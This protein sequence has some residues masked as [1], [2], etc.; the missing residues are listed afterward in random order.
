[1]KEADRMD[2][3]ATVIVRDP[4]LAPLPPFVRS[5]TVNDPWEP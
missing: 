1:V 2:I 4:R 5:V 3:F